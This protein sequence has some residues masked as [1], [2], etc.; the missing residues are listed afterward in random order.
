[1]AGWVAVD[2]VAAL[3]VPVVSSA[4]GSP[5]SGVRTAAAVVGPG[6]EVVDLAVRHRDVTPRP[7]ALRRCQLDGQLGGSGEEP[8]SASEVDDQTVGAGHDPTDVAGEGVGDGFGGVDG[9]AVEG[10]APV[11]DGPAASVGPVAVV[12]RV[13][14]GVDGAGVGAGEAVEVAF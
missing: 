9:V 4:G 8:A 2:G 1:M 12:G 10:G 13:E 5:V 3:F 11:P 7:V 14:A 6:D